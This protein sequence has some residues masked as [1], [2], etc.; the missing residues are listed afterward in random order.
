MTLTCDLH[1]PAEIGKQMMNEMK[2]EI[3]SEVSI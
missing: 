3:G 2:I 1:I